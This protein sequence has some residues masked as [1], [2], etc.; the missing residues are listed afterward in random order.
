MIKILPTVANGC[1]AVNWRANTV[2]NR[3]SGRLAGEYE[4]SWGLAGDE[5]DPLRGP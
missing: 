4:G 5:V 3:T 1:E 2:E